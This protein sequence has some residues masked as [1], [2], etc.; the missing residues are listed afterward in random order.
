[1][2]TAYSQTASTLQDKPIL[3]EGQCSSFFLLRFVFAPSQN[4]NLFNICSLIAL[5]LGIVGLSFSQSSIFNGCFLDLLETTFSICFLGQPQC[6]SKKICGLMFSKLSCLRFGLKE[7]KGFFITSTFLGWIVSN[8]LVL[9]LLLGVLF[10]NS[11]QIILFKI[12]LNWNALIF[13]Y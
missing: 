9:R 1:M 3:H 13:L 5:I 7:I 6:Q 12:C 8:R 4:S 10:Q 2:V 11:M